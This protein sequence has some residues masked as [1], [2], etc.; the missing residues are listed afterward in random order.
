MFHSYQFLVNELNSSSLIQIFNA[1]N[2]LKNN[3]NQKETLN[4]KHCN[5]IKGEVAR[6]TR[7]LA[8]VTKSYQQQQQQQQGSGGNAVVNTAGPTFASKV[9]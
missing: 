8:E 5:E 3:V 6:V 7:G 2:E 9:S 1:F 4:V